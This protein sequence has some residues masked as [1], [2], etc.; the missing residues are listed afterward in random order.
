MIGSA[1]QKRY[2]LAH[3]LLAV[4]AA[5]VPNLGGGMA[6]AAEARSQ[7]AVDRSAGVKRPAPVFTYRQFTTK[8]PPLAPTPDMAGHVEA[9]AFD[10]SGRP[11]VPPP[12]PVLGQD[13]ADRQE[14]ADRIGNTDPATDTASA[15]TDLPAVQRGQ[16][17]SSDGSRSTAAGT[18]RSRQPGSADEQH[19]DAGKAKL[20]GSGRA[21]WYQHTG[22]TASGEIYNPDRL[23]A[24][25]H[26]LPFGTLLKVVNK[27]N[28]RSVTVKITDRTNERTKMKRNY[29]IDLSR[30]SARK[31]GLD[32][33]GQV[34]LYKVD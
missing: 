32:G 27:A 12:D 28:G 13:R 6:Q 23:T 9:T 8:L 5:L 33:I 7:D 15:R 22:K 4:S 21:S 34:A 2:R 17:A 3:M 18:D 16:D 1:G 20:I 29:A 14:R 25:H 11:S 10:P 31:I 30:A 19:A 24:A 26:T